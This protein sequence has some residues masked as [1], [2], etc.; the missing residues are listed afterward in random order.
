MRSKVSNF[1]KI[2]APTPLPSICFQSYLRIPNKFPDGF[3]IAK[4]A[5]KL[6]MEKKK[7]KLNIGIEA[8]RALG[9][10]L[11]TNIYYMLGELIANAYDADAN[12][13]Y[14]NQAEDELRVED[15]GLGMSYETIEHTYLNV[16]EETRTSKKGERTPGGRTKIGRKGIGKLAAVAISNN[17]DVMTIHQGEKNGF[18]LFSNKYLRQNKSDFLLTPIP[19]DSISF[20]HIKRQ[21]TAVVMRGDLQYSLEDEP[22]DIK[23]NLLK[24]FGLINDNFKIHIAIQGKDKITI[25]SAEDNISRKMGAIIALGDEFIGLANKVTPF[26][27]EPKKKKVITDRGQTIRLVETLPAHK[28]TI[29]LENNKNEKKEYDLEIKGW[30]GTLKKPARRAKMS[31][32]DFPRKHISLF[33]NNK[34]GEYDILPKVGNNRLYEAYIVG[35]FHVDLFEETELPD[36]ALSN[37]Q[38]YKAE[39]PRYQRVIEYIRENIMGNAL[40]QIEARRDYIRKQE[41]SD[42]EK[43][44]E[45]HIEK[46]NIELNKQTDKIEGDIRSD[47]SKLIK[48]GKGSEKQIADRLVS[49]A[50]ELVGLQETYK[51]DESVKKF[52]ISHTRKDKEVGTFIY[53]LLMYNGVP[54]EDIL[55]T[56]A[57]HPASRIPR[58]NEIYKYLHKVFMN[59][60]SG[61]K[62]QV[63]FVTS[64]NLPKSWGAVV[65]VGASWVTRKDHCIFNINGYEPKNPLDIGKEWIDITW[66]E[67][68]NGGKGEISALGNEPHKIYEQIES[69]LKELPYGYKIKSRRENI[70]YIKNYSTDDSDDY[71]PEEI[72][73]ADDTEA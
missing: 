38:G 58:Y 20:L 57:M 5:N 36:M 40:E 72:E 2:Y 12:N 52:L 10:G 48:E 34:L 61:A 6:K 24:L 11:Y 73:D 56:S 71:S 30:I 51:E 68:A 53:K 15:D 63:I 42:R 31:F 23:E 60:R 21:G 18:V 65:E 9:P 70:E 47:V 66:D 17:V 3:N 4:R 41:L 32:V 59:T 16:G 26:K 29:V 33:A 8:I 67:K 39:D 49:S 22:N 55:F 28:E 25:D 62:M 44:L 64:K 13:V 69:M 19:E 7:Y 43:E 54:R 45:K 27:K 46:R 1:T 50:Y 35:Q 37:R 14:I